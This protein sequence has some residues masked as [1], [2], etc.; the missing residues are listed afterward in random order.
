V[1]VTRRIGN[2]KSHFAPNATRINEEK[3]GIKDCF[4]IKFDLKEEKADTTIITHVTQ[5]IAYTMAAFE[6]AVGAAD[7]ARTAQAAKEGGGTDEYVQVFVVGHGPMGDEF[8]KKV[9]GILGKVNTILVPWMCY[10]GS[11]TTR[12]SYVSNGC[13]P[14]QKEEMRNFFAECAQ[15]GVPEAVKWWN[16]E[17]LPDLRKKRGLKG[18]Q[19]LLPRGRVRRSWR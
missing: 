12:P 18:L 16:N 15:R 1:R 13:L 19:K 9:D 7:A 3:S 17:R 4:L 10:T 14:V 2:N 11:V 5:W 8:W 6:A